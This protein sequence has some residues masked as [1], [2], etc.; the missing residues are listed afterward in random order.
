M[1]TLTYIFSVEIMFSF[2]KLN[3]QIS[4]QEIKTKTQ[5]KYLGVILDEHLNFKKQIETV[6]EKLARATGILAKLRHYVPKKVLKSI[7]YVIFDSNM[8]YSCQIWGQN[9]NTLLRD[10]EKLQNKAI[11]IIN[12][13]TGSLH[14]NNLFNELKILKDLIT[15]NNC[16]FVF[17][18]LKEDLPQ[19]FKN[20]FLK[21]YD[22]HICNTQGTKKTLLNVPLKNTSKYG[23]K[24][25]T[26]R[27]IFNWNDMNKKIK[28]SLEISRTNFITLLRY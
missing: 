23:T 5:T 22:H 18:Q 16:L 9:S 19:A 3:F 7:Y 8:K 10:I 21:K 20:F 11:N 2:R 24:S 14:L 15:F 12:S 26:S 6:K 4:G 28:F 1:K 17:D 27:S 13:K 25:I